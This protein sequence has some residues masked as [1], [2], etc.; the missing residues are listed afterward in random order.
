MTS[1]P[2]TYSL[3]HT[4]PRLPVPSLNESCALYLK[5]LLPLQTPEEHEKTKAIVNDFL[6]SPLAHS[7]QQRLIDIE[8]TSPNNWLED[9]YWLKKAYLEWREPLMVNSNW[10]IILKNDDHHPKE[11]LENNAKVLPPKQLSAFQIRRAANMIY[12]GLDYKEKL[13]REEIPIEMVRGK[14]PLCMRQ[15]SRIFGITRIPLHHCDELYQ[16]N[17]SESN[18][19]IVLVCDQIYKL[20]VYKEVNG[21]KQRLSIDELERELSVIASHALQKKNVQPP[22]SLLTSWDRDNWALA[23][24]YL[25]SIDPKGNRQTLSTIENGLF[26]VALDD[27]TLG[28]ELDQ[29]PTTMFCGNHLY[30]PGHNRWYDKSVTIVV[31]NNGKSGIMG[32]HSPADALT[33]SYVADHMVQHSVVHGLKANEQPTWLSNKPMDIISQPEFSSLVEHL[34]W[35]TDNQ[36]HRYLEQAQL[37]ANQTAARS[38]PY[39]LQF[40]EFG[41]D[42]I[43]KVGKLPPDAFYQMVLQL[44]YYR[45][46]GKVTATYETASTRKYLFGRTETIR[47]CSLDSKNFVEAF[48][49]P[50][51]SAKEKYDLLA[52]AAEAHR[53]YTQIASDGHGCDRHLLI[54]KILNSDHQIHDPTT[55]ELK[56]APLHPIFKDP[57]Y[58]E[59][60]NWRLSTSGLQPGVQLM[61]TGFGAVAKDGYGINYMA[62]RTLVKFGMESKKDEQSLPTRQFADII[63]KVLLDLRSLCEQVN[64]SSTKNDSSAKL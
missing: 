59:S 9:N 23:R 41:T 52:K 37:A 4:L 13:E 48:D 58:S 19:I 51:I 22:I 31:E 55:G 3:Q 42:W 53:K 45:A 29:W 64:A 57:I 27:F 40:K 12:Y 60:Q 2:P 49:N 39:V 24:N 5:S 1:T 11:L 56:Q 18:H 50:S 44:A 25:L 34:T 6:N 28:S 17:I 36:V 43:K 26:A 21:N 38:D 32:E 30:G 62:A 54:L 8:R 47:S 14:S 16:P 20:Q 15:Y 46:H 63:S 10:Y 61:G 35:T 33:V 7:L